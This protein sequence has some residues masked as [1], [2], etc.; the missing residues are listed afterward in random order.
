MVDL[1]CRS[2][3]LDEAYNFI[4]RMPLEPNAVIWGASFGACKIHC[5][6]ELG[7][8][9][10]E[11]LFELEPE[12]EGYHIL[13]SNIYVVLG[14]WDNVAKVRI[15]MKDRG[16]KKKPG[17]SWIEVK[18]KGMNKF[19]V[20]AFVGGDKS[21]PE[22][23][24][25]Y[26]MLE[27]LFRQM[28]DMGYVPNINFVLDDVDDDKEKE[29]ILLAHSEKLAIAFGIIKTCPGIA[30]RI[31]KN[32]RICGDCHIATKFIS[33]IVGR[34]I[35]VRDMNRFHCFKDGLCSCRDYW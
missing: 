14:R 19:W 7:Q 32:L 8:H 11:H 33:R 1:L 2:G 24:K 21:H 31:T 4:K 12:N 23:D 15:M 18:D 28:K 17:C 29:R 22:S 20:H 3:N 16:L 25:I 13:L 26:A 5:N 35:I 30:I 34:E 10:A 9:V 6:I 27:S